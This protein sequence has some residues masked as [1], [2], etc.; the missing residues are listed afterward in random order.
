M[1][2]IDYSLV[3]Q[4]WK[5]CIFIFQRIVMLRFYSFRSD[6]P[7]QFSIIVRLQ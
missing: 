6:D 1:H 2:E 5:Q 4:S 7:P 3:Y